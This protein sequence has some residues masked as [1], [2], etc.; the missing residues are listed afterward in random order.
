MEARMSTYAV[1]G[2]T[3]HR[4]LEEAY[5]RVPTH[6]H[7]KAIDETIWRERCNEYAD[8][9][10]ESGRC[11]QLS[12]KFDAPHYAAEFLAIAKKSESRHLHIKAYCHTGE[13]DPKTKKPIRKWVELGTP[14]EAAVRARIKIGD[15]F[16]ES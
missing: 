9:L 7:M 16:A 13:R 11:I 3:R 6:E 12:E 14:E 15:V 5:E 2:M 10:M 1:W 8:R 4:A